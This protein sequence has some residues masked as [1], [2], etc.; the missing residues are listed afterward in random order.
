MYMESEVSPLNEKLAP[1]ANTTG[2]LYTRNDSFIRSWRPPGSEMSQ[3][4]QMPQRDSKEQTETV[5][6]NSTGEGTY[7]EVVFIQE[8]FWRVVT[9]NVD[10]GERVVDSLL[11]ISSSQG[12][13]KEGQKDLESVVCLNFGD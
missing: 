4:P 13:F 10:L 9:I 2:R 12:S 6:N 11:G 1:C 8:N 3:M 7:I 5:I